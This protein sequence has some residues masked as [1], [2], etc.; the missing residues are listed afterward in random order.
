MNTLRYAERSRTI[1]NSVKQNVVKAMLT[2]AE[3]AALRGENKALK[4]KLSVLRKRVNVLEQPRT[5]PSATHSLLDDIHSTF[6][7]LCMDPSGETEMTASSQSSLGSPTNSER[8]GIEGQAVIKKRATAEAAEASLRSKGSLMDQSDSISETS[9]RSKG[10]LLDLSDGD[11][12]FFETSTDEVVESEKRIGRSL[13]SENNSLRM[14][15]KNL[16]D[17]ISARQNEIKQYEQQATLVRHEMV[18]VESVLQR[19]QK[20]FEP[21]ASSAFH[22][23][24]K[25]APGQAIEMADLSNKPAPPTLFHDE[26]ETLRSKLIEAE[27]AAKNLEVSLACAN[28]QV[29]QLKTVEISLQE[30][31][32][33]LREDVKR[34]EREREQSERDLDLLVDEAEVLTT[35]RNE[36]RSDA[37]KHKEEKKELRSQLHVQSELVTELR[38]ELE[39]KQKELEHQEQT[40]C[41]YPYDESKPNDADAVQKEEEEEEES[42]VATNDS[43]GSVHKDIRIQA[44]K[45]LFYANQAIE[46]GRSGRSVASCSIV[47]GNASEYKPDMKELHALM[48]QNR[49]QRTERAVGKPPLFLQTGA[50]ASNNMIVISNIDKISDPCSCE[51]SFFSGNS[52]HAEF[53]L[54]K[55]GMACK[56][57]NSASVTATLD[58]SDPCALGN[59]L[60]PW[61]VDFL[62]TMGIHGSVDLV[63]AFKERGGE[64]AKAM[65]KW[66]KE[67]KQPAIKTK[68]CHIAL[69]VWSRTCKCVVHAVR[70]QKAEGATVITRPE[71]LEISSDVHTIST[72]GY[73]SK[74]EMGEI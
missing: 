65:R 19:Q 73:G 46:K 4:V 2:P 71:F 59:I 31:I 66:R 6:D 39:I 16:M 18:R 3:C 38:G 10:S 15:N 62:A 54:P 13:K 28:A 37:D 64:L 52:L 68:S 14:E 12:E 23:V 50:D 11:A 48:N 36:A 56:C 8:S 74:A 26:S 53:Y 9:L 42:S 58:G 72:L 32:E 34:E 29:S 49:R 44:A 69:H 5:N 7:E 47:S 25:A 60:R 35:E 55:L 1:T 22:R 61:Q 24:V 40:G 57:G 51:S 33:Q 17:Q 43:K 20:R 41:K 45:M 63:H 27:A 30:E 67:N 21:S 70:K